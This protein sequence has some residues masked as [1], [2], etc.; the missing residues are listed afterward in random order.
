MKGSGILKSK[1]YLLQ[2]REKSPDKFQAELSQSLNFTFKKNQALKI[3][4]EN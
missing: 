4:A 3:A 1:P 2:N